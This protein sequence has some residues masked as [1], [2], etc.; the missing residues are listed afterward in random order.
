MTT[1]TRQN[2]KTCGRYMRIVVIEYNE[3]GMCFNK[4][5]SNYCEYPTNLTHL[6]KYFENGAKRGSFCLSIDINQKYKVID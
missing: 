1:L 2:C 4:K 3:F 5:C 6:E